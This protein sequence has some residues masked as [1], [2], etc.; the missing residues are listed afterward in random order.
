[1]QQRGEYEKELIK[2]VSHII[3]RTSWDR[4]NTWAINPNAQYHFC[5]ETLRPQ[6]YRTNWDYEKCN[7]HTIFLSQGYYPLKGIQQVLHALPLILSHYPDTK[8]LVAGNNF[9]NK[10]SYLIRSCFDFIR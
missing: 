3:G 8:I 10:K 4:A 9:I 6:F 1:M 5:N 7:K 2:T